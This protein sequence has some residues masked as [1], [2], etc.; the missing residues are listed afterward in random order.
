MCD[1]GILNSQIEGAGMWIVILLQCGLYFLSKGSKCSPNIHAHPLSLA[2]TVYAHSF[3]AGRCW[4]D[5]NAGRG[6]QINPS[7]PHR[8]FGDPL[9]WFVSERRN[10]D[11][12]RY[13]NA[14][15]CLNA[16]PSS[17]CVIE[18]SVSAEWRPVFKGSRWRSAPTCSCSADIITT[19]RN[20]TVCSLKATKHRR[21]YDGERPT[22]GEFTDVEVS[23]YLKPLCISTWIHKSLFSE[24]FLWNITVTVPQTE[25][26]LWR[27]DT[28]WTPN[29]S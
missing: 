9:V 25:P 1:S 12:K 5:G 16:V 2:V 29:R 11:P 17:R 19:E 22:R 8:A 6:I 21:H 14:G 18:D 3:E 28:V 26:T 20:S 10:A 23:V 4:I 15:L 27:F 24:S 13:I 7:W